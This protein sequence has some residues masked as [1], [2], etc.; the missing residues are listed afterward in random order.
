[1]YLL[2]FMTAL[3]AAAGSV[4]FVSEATTGVWMM[5]GACLFGIFSRLAQADSHHGKVMAALQKLQQ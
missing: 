2:F 3:L 1:M 5:C 4:M